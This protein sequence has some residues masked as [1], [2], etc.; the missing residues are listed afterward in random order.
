MTS[1]SEGLVQPHKPQTKSLN[2]LRVEPRPAQGSMIPH[3]RNKAF[4]LD[5]GF[6]YFV[7]QEHFQSSPVRDWFSPTYPQRKP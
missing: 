2:P 4:I 5:E 6:L 7:F 3:L 1:T